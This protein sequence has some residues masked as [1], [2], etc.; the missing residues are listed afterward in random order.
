[1]PLQADSQIV[2]VDDHLFEPRTTW[3]S[4]VP[5]RYAE[6]APHLIE[7]GNVEYWIYEQQAFIAYSGLDITVT[8]DP[9]EYGWGGLHSRDIPAA[10]TDPV[11]RAADMDID[12]VA[13]QACFPTFPRFAGTRFLL[14]S[15][16]MKLALLCVQAYNDFV[17]DEWCAAVPGRFIP[18][19]IL[20]LWDVSLAVAELERVAAKGARTVSF[21]ENFEPLG[22]P[23]I[24]SHHWD[25]VFRAAEA[26]GLPLSIHFGTSGK[27]PRTSADAPDAVFIS[28]MATNSMATAADYIFSHAFDK[29]PRLRVALSEGGIGWIPYMIERLD[30]TWERQRYLSRLGPRRP[31]EVFREH[32]YGCFIDDV[33]GVAQRD[34]IGVNNLMLESDYPHSDTSWPN[35]RKRAQEV[36]AMVNDEDAARIAEW[37]ARELYNFPR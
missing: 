22:L 26:A 18:V 27:L 21:P 6:R 19:A 4:R 33:A 3:T 1:M 29:F 28:L 9:S 31:S 7:D 36:L 10:C 37:N 12:G 32:L 17:I 2:S 14:D 23:S 24:H 11:A 30:Y 13:V 35:T 25:P 16:D 5:A 8:R 20:P 15:K 34:Q